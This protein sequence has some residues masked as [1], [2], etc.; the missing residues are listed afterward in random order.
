[1]IELRTQEELPRRAA[2]LAILC[3]TGEVLN[4]SV[5]LDEILNMILIGATAGQGL[6]FNRAF[7][8]LVDERERCLK[9]SLA[10]GPDSAEE[11]AGIWKDLEHKRFSLREMLLTHGRELPG[12]GSRVKKIVKS[13]RV[14]LEDD[15]HVL[16]RALTSGKAVVVG[17]H[18][19]VDASVA[20][21][22]GGLGVDRFALVPILSRSGP[23]GVLLADNA[24]THTPIS[25]ADLDILRLYANHAGTAIEKARLYTRVLE[26]K[27]ALETAHRDLRRNQQTIINLQRLSDLGEMAARVAHEIRNPLVTIGGFARRVLGMT[28]AGDPRGKHLQIIVSEV[29]RLETILT[30]VLDYARPFKLSGVRLD[31]NQLVRQTLDAFAPEYEADDVDV[32]VDL[33][34]SFGR[35]TADAG[36]LRIA[37]LNLLRNALQAIPRQGERRGRITVRTKNL[38]PVVEVAVE[39]NGE[40]IAADTVDKIMEPFFTTKSSGSGLGLAIV[41]QILKEHGG[42]V[43]FESKPGEG[44]AF[45]LDLPREKGRA[46]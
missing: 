8:L 20:E 27:E 37:L 13:L 5:E 2:D 18:D 36:L 7:L 4:S 9:G 10:I 44:A 24:I 28:E 17:P 6:R 35:I 40:G 25:Q 3:E 26:E 33:D 45:F 30:E 41:S 15:E 19:A 38:G 11:A 22:A 43:R 14:A 34:E 1:M 46:A 16:V 31:L 42:R 39:D 12:A 29:A 21:V 23:V 32:V